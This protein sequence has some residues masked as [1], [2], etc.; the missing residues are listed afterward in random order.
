MAVSHSFTH[1]PSL[2]G[3]ADLVAWYAFEE[4]NASSFVEDLS[5]S[6]NH[7]QVT[8]GEVVPGKFGQSLQLDSS[9]HLTAD[10]DWLSLTD[11]LTLSLWVKVLDDSQGILFVTDSFPCNIMTML[12]C[13]DLSEPTVVGGK[14]KFA[15]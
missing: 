9:S 8:G 14:P 5:G 10:G 4:V 7:G 13:A 2:V 3:E 6:G 12:P 11:S 15:C 1:K